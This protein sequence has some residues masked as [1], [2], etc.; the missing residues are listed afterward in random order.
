M[1]VV[2]DCC[3]DSLG[4]FVWDLLLACWHSVGVYLFCGWL[5]VGLIGGCGVIVLM[6]VVVCSW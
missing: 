5:M 2:L 1:N 6:F 4:C 3:F